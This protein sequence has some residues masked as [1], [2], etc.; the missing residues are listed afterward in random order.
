MAFL[1]F[2][3]IIPKQLRTLHTDLP[4]KP[5]QPTSIG[6]HAVRHLLTLHCSTSSWYFSSF[7]S[8]ATSMFSSHGTVS[9]ISST[10]FV[11]VDQ[12]IKS[13]G[14]VVV[15]ICSGTFKRFLISTLYCQSWAADSKQELSLH[16]EGG[17]SP[18]WTK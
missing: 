15:A 2:S 4:V 5:R 7:L 1:F 3:P 17:H 8:Q 14:S 12:R 10:C 13:G 18:A 11:S 16:A 9:S 6:W